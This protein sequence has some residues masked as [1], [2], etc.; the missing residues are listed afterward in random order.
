ME[1]KSRLGY[2]NPEYSFIKLKD[3]LVR[4]NSGEWGD[5]PDKEFISVIRGTNFNNDGKLDISDIALRYLT[6]EQ[7]K[8]KKL[9]ENDI[10]VERSGGSD[11][12][13]VGRVG[14]VD[15]RIAAINCSCANFIQRI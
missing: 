8:K 5:D 15:K 9:Y 4:D 3:V 13:P 6:P 12:Q 14:F 2:I 10:I 11:S 1:L 7:I